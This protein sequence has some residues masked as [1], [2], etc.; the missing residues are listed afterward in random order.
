M[1]HVRVLTRKPN[2]AQDIPISA[3]I[4]FIVAVLTAFTPLLV[5]KDENKG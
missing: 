1:K 2:C 5:V 3:M 4:S